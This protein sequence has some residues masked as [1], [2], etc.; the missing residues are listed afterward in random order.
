MPMKGKSAGK[1]KA[2]GKSRAAARGKNRSSKAYAK[3]KK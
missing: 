2:Y 1:G 3:R